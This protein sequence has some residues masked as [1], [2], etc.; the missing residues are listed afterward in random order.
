VGIYP[1]FSVPKMVSSSP[2][3]TIIID[4]KLGRNKW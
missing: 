2:S 4:T 1:Y 3:A